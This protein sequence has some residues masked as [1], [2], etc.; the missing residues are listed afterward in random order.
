MG[1]HPEKHC[2]SQ[3]LCH[4]K[5]EGDKN[6]I[7]TDI[8]PIGKQMSISATSEKTNMP[9]TNKIALF[10]LL[11]SLVRE[12]RTHLPAYLVRKLLFI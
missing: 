8:V 5:Q 1:L 9:D 2:D 3:G 7:V 6:Q 11:L 12:D 4:E 10:L